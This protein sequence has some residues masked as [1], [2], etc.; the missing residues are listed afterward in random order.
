MNIA[1]IAWPRFNPYKK[2]AVEIYVSGCYNGCKNC[3]N[4]QLQNFD[5]GR[6]FDDVYL[7]YLKERKDFFDIISFMG[8]DLMCQD[9]YDALH[10]VILLK[11]VFSN[12]QF[13][14]FTGFE[15]NEVPEWCKEQF[16]YIKT[17]RYIEELKQEGFP[18]SSNQ[19]LLKKGINY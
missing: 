8:G 6:V 19:K 17:G 2:S 10:L 3:H 7:N 5:L 1:N 13:W 15:I 16:D 4:S 11:N 18:A 12:K 14:L 9:Q